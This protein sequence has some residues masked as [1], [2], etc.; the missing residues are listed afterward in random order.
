MNPGRTTWN[1][2]LVGL[3]LCTAPGRVRVNVQVQP[4]KGPPPGHVRLLPGFDYTVDPTYDARWGK[5]FKKDGVEISWSDGFVVDEVEHSEK[6]GDVVWRKEQDVGG[7]RYHVAL[8]KDGTV[9]ISAG[10]T[11]FSVGCTNFSAK[12][13]TPEQFAELM[14]VALSCRRESEGSKK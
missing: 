11:A 8:R 14:L 3:L 12:P 5:I 10:T 2:A 4:D 6:A 1:T 13:T 9:V 7:I